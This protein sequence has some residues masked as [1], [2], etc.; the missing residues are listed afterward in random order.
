MPY[1]IL[2]ACGVLTA[3]ASAEAAIKADAE[4][5]GYAYT[6]VRPGQLFGGPYD[7]NVY[8][9]TPLF[10]L[11]K[12][13]DERDVLLGRG[14]VTLNDDPQLGTLRS[15]LAEVNQCVACRRVDQH[16]TATIHPDTQVDVPRSSLRPET[17]S[18]QNM[19]Q[20]QGRRADGA[21][22][23]GGPRRWAR[24]VLQGPY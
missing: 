1:P 11:D 7:N 10:Q 5:G 6:F 16:E 20:R 12:D 2:N 18:A 21:R 15:T 3:K 19:R 4:K 8:L 13:A 22:A 24:C 17:G 23:A 9:G 14:D